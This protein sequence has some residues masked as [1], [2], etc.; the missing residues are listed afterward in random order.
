MEQSPEKKPKLKD[1]C[2]GCGKNYRITP[3]NAAWFD[4]TQKPEVKVLVCKC[5]HCEFITTIYIPESSNTIDIAKAI[6]IQGETR[7]YPSD[8]VLEGFY[9]VM[10]IELIQPQALTQRKE[11]VVQYLGYLLENDLITPD[12]WQAEGEVII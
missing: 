12:D 2:N 4:Y 11:K 7:D 3:D 6:G 8:H 5:T 1:N 9:D 10:G